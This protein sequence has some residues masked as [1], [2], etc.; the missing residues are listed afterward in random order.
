LDNAFIREVASCLRMYCRGSLDSPGEDRLISIAATIARQKLWGRLRA[1]ALA[2]NSTPEEESLSLLAGLFVKTDQSSHLNESLKEYLDCDDISLFL[3]FQA[4]VICTVSQELFHRWREN[5]PVSAKLWRNLQRM[6]RHD[7][8]III[9][10]PDKPQWAVLADEN[11]APKAFEPVTY[12]NIEGLI[13]ECVAGGKGLAET[14]INVLNVA[15]S[16]PDQSCAVRIEDIF[17]GLRKALASSG[18]IELEKRGQAKFDDPYLCMAT[19][20]ALK[21]IRSNL[22]EIIRRYK[23]KNKLNPENADLFGKSLHDLLSDYSDGGLSQSYYDYLHE[24]W[25]DL[26]K[27]RYRS[28]Y[29]AKFEYLAE[30]VLKDFIDAMKREYYE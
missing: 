11:K 4:I 7:K 3:R 13:G 29:R 2:N 9:F 10:P 27:E 21:T 25:P 22:E 5:D 28:E 20:R 15:I 6:L 19:D 26:S 24:Y 23:S 8:R 16:N 1:A 12:D 30:Y 17:L 14:I 18:A